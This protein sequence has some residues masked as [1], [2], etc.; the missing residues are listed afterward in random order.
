MALSNIGKEPRREITESVI[1]IGV[2]VGYIFADYF[3]VSW[4]MSG[5]QNHTD[6]VVGTVLGMLG[7]IVLVPISILFLL[8]THALGDGI[9]NW[10]AALGADPRPRRRR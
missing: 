6:Q 5:A 9:C 10:F 8:A 2:V 1:G 4:L 3:V 7:G